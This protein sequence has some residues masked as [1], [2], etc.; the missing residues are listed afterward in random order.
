MHIYVLLLD[1]HGEGRTFLV[2]APFQLSLA[3]NNPFSKVAYFGVACSDCPEM[4]VQLSV[5][6][7]LEARLY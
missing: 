1:T 3:Q 2:S 5:G 7:E 4:L 6:V